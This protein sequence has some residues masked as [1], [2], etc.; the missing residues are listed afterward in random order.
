VSADPQPRDARIVRRALIAGAI[1]GGLLA[2][3]LGLGL[4]GGGTGAAVAGVWSGLAVG[5][6][7][8]AGWLLLALG[9]DVVA[10]VRPGR[11][12]LLWTAGLTLLALLLPLLALAAGSAP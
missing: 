4:S 2:A 7:A 12:R 10:G 5:G 3:A 9:L 11:A 8:A 6:F 1:V